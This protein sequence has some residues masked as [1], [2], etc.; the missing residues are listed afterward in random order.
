MKLNFNCIFVLMDYKKHTKDR[1]AERF[2]N[3]SS[4]KKVGIIDI[5]DED[6][7]KMC[8]LASDDSKGFLKKITNRGGYKKII[9]YNGIPM[10]CA[11]SEKK[12]IIRTV[13]PIKNSDFRKIKN[14]EKEIK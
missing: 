14:I 6:Y 2:Q 4:C 7:F 5:T 8:E 11:V 9:F 12:K 1:F 10:W 3:V 13:Y